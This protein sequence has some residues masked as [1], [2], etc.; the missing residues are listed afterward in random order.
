MAKLL[1]KTCSKL[2]LTKIQR[3]MYLK[4]TIEVTNDVYMLLCIKSTF[5]SSL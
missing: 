5:Y 1:L 3:E 2:T 4:S